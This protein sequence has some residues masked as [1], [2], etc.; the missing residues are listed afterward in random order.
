MTLDRRHGRGAG[1][2]LVDLTVDPD[3]ALL[4]ELYCQVLAPAFPAHELVS[5]A[6]LQQPVGGAE[7]GCDVVVAVGSERQPVAGIVAQWFP[8]SAVLLLAYLAVRPELRGTGIGTL[9]IEEAVPAWLQRHHPLLTVGEVEHPDHRGASAAY[10]DPA[11]RLRLYE[12][13]GAR[14]VAAPYFQPRI[15][16][17]QERAYDML[18]LVF[19]VDPSA[20][21]ADGPV[22]TIDGGILAR[23]LDEYFA[24]SEG[25]DVVASDADFLAMRAAMNPPGGLRLIP[26]HRYREVPRLHRR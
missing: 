25:A 9:L 7:H 23:F 16:P 12:R 1:P 3:P 5:L 15:A 17:A 11:A 24:D 10:G 13:L 20:Y 21:R 2:E 22:P 26:V 18:L 8:A 6:S 4:S 14:L 19:D